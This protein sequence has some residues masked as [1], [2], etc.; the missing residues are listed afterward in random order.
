MLYQIVNVRDNIDCYQFDLDFFI[1]NIE[2]LKEKKSDI[3]I[4]DFINLIVSSYGIIGNTVTRS[5]LYAM[6][7]DIRDTNINLV[8]RNSIELTRCIIN[9]KYSNEY[10]NKKWKYILSNI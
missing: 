6:R 10:V 8:L 9:N 3:N 1:K 7:R 4:I 2:Y 5:V